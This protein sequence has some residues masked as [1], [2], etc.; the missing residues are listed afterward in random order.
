MPYT[1]IDHIKAGHWYQFRVAAVNIYG[2]RG[3]STPSQPFRL[4]KGSPPLQL[5]DI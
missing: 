4:S 2:S 5:A 3:W 1:I